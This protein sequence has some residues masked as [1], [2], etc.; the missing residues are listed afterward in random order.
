LIVTQ[1]L[2][3]VPAFTE[4]SLQLINNGTGPCPEPVQTGPQLPHNIVISER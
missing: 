4:G 3:T 1:L 2:E